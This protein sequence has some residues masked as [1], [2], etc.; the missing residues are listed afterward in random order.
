MK[1]RAQSN[2]SS[3]SSNPYKNFINISKCLFFVLC[4][5]YYYF[6]ICVFNGI[7]LTEICFDFFFF[8]FSFFH[9]NHFIYVFNCFLIVKFS[10]IILYSNL[11][12]RN[13]GVCREVW[14]QV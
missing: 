6:M 2:L 10:Y 1:N 9:S 13:F 14:R 11:Y 12:K 8:F 4:D 5:F 7:Q 3:S